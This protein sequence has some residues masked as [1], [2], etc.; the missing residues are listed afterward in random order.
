M[1][2][3]NTTALTCSEDRERVSLLVAIP[4]FLPG[5]SGS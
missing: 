4:E 1:L 2:T 5:M 3:G